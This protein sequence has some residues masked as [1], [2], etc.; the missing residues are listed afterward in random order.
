[1]KDI[2]KAVFTKLIADTTLKTL[3]GYTSSNKNIRSFEGLKQY[4]FDKYLLFGKLTAEQF[5]TELDT[6]DVRKYTMQIQ[7][8]DR[9]NDINVDDI[10]E[11]VIDILHNTTLSESGSM[12]SLLCEWE[13]SLPTFYDNELSFYV[14]LSYYNL[15][16][17]KLN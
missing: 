4:K 5:D 11:R 10:N 6:S 2:L 16:I 3:L 15:I 8:F 1:M 12:K 9:K 7:S 17:T 14:K 13:R